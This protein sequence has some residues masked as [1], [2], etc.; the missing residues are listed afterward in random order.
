MDQDNWH[1]ATAIHSQFEQQI[2][3]TGKYRHRPLML[4]SEDNFLS[5]RTDRF[6]FRGYGEWRRGPAPDLNIK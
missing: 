5:K 4:S 2:S 1:D 6:Q 3:R